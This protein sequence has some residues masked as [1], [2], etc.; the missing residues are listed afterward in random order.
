[1]WTSWYMYF[2]EC[3]KFGCNSK[4]W[5]HKNSTKILNSKLWLLESHQCKMSLCQWNVKKIA[6]S[7]HLTSSLQN[8]ICK[9][10]RLKWC[11]V[12]KIVLTCCEK[13]KCFSDREKTIEI[14]RTIYS[15]CERSEQFLKPN[16]FQLFTWGSLQSDWIH[17]NN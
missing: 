1:M 4:K 2:W 5:L 16:T 17:L 6:D 14:N 7:R 15:N 10:A 11:F 13:K 9:K 12:S 3:L 8:P